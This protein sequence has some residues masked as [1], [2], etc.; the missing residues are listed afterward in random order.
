MRKVDQSRAHALAAVAR[1]ALPDSPALRAFRERGIADLETAGLPVGHEAWRFTPPNQLVAPEL[2]AVATPGM[3]L[4][5]PDGLGD[6]PFAHFV[7]G[8]PHEATLP[9]FSDTQAPLPD[10]QAGDDGFAALNRAFFQ[11]GVDLVLEGDARGAYHIVHQSTVPLGLTANRHRIYVKS[12]AKVQ[13]VEHVQGTD[14]PTFS[15][16][17]TDVVVEGGARVSYVRISTGGP[18]TRQTARITAEIQEGAHFAA[19]SF[20]IGGHTTRVELTANLRGPGADVTFFGLALLRG[21]SHADQ[22]V[23]ARH[24]MPHAT[25]DQVFRSI[26]D[27]TSQSIYTGTVIVDKGALGTDSNQLH[28]AL[29][30]SDDAT[31]HARPWLEIYADDVKCAHGAT[32]GSLDADSLFYLR[33]RGLTETEAR[34]LLMWA[35]ATGTVE[36][37]PEGPVRDALSDQV[38]QWL[39]AS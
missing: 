38:R 23:T 32:V 36:Q 13:L 18:G 3:A 7:D 5:R 21:Q 39:E 8:F 35:F 31:V 6:A 37:L 34:G 1:E 22:H 28:Q 12:G 30:L 16:L 25:S 11:D 19:G 20:I 9:R 29:L 33:Q 15:T 26:V 14:D 4:P 2:T 27:G 10:A 24:A 17:L